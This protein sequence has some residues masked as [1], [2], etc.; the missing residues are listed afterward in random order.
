MMLHNVVSRAILRFLSLYQWRWE[1]K[2]CIWDFSLNGLSVWACLLHSW[3]ITV[4]PMA[5]RVR[6]GCAHGPGKRQCSGVI[7]RLQ[8]SLPPS[9]LFVCITV[10][11][12][13]WALTGLTSPKLVIP[14]KGGKMEH[15]CDVLAQFWDESF[16]FYHAD[17][18]APTFR[19]QVSL[20]LSSRAVCVLIRVLMGCLLVCRIQPWRKIQN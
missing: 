16:I 10:A 7:Q 9:V 18:S 3:A 2:I 14:A 6:K 19:T 17:Q 4:H 13:M 20:R 15:L 5:A 8:I 12:G 11:D 1:C